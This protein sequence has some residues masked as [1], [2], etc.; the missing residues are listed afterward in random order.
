M[1]LWQRLFHRKRLE[2]QLESE[3]EFH[4]QQQV[5]DYMASGMTE[6]EARRR[7]RLAFGG[8]DHI[9][10]DCRE[11]RAFSVLE[12]TLQDAFYALRITRKSWVFSTLVVLSLA[13]VIGANTAIFTLIDA[14]MWR[15]LPVK[16]P[17]TLLLA[18]FTQVR[19]PEYGLR[20]AQPVLLPGPS[21]S[22]GHSCRLICPVQR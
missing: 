17:E 8:V 5:R 15:T 3:I 18:G 7:A 13:L 12:T 21:R 20:I 11:V 14:V 9:K 22:L 1:T 6:Q 10:E 4:L 16:D 19:P 2:R